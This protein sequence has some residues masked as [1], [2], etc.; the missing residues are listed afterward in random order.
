MGF[1]V[2]VFHEL[3]WQVVVKVLSVPIDKW[4]EPGE[5]WW[6]SVLKKAGDGVAGVAVLI[7]TKDEN[8]RTLVGRFY[9][10]LSEEIAERAR[11][12]VPPAKRERIAA[13]WKYDGF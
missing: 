10:Q 6:T 8:I 11:R 9:E 2:H 7:T 1:L 4:V 3:T 12:E 5:E 13:I